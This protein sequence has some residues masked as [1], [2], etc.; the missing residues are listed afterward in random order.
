ML[1]TI[2]NPRRTI[3]KNVKLLFAFVFTL[4]LLL[5][6][7][8]SATVGTLLANRLESGVVQTE[9]GPVRGFRAGQTFAYLGVPFAAPPVGDLRWQ[10]PAALAC[11]EGE[12]QA[13]SFS[14][15]CPQA[16]D[17]GSV[18]G[19]EDCLYVNVWTPVGAS[20]TSSLPVMVFIHG[21]GNVQGSSSVQV[22]DVYLYDGQLLAERGQVVVMT[23]QYRLGALGFLA[24]PG[25]SAESERGISGN[26]GL[27]DQIAALKWVQRNIS[28]FGGDP[29]RVMIFGESAG[30]VD[31]CMLLASP[32]ATG[33]FSRA[34][35]ESGGC[36]ARTLA[37]RMDEGL[38][39]AS[40]AGC[41][42]A[43]DPV[44]CLRRLDAATLVKA[45]DTQPVNPT[46][47]VT[48]QFGPN[49]DGYVL[50]QPPMDA[51]RNGQH[52]HASFI[53]GANADE[54]AAFGIPP[55][56]Q[57]Q[58]REIVIQILGPTLGE[59][60]LAEYPVRE[61]GTPRQ[62]LIAMTTDAQFVCPCRTIARAAAASQ[63]EPV[64]RYF[65]TQRLSRLPGSALGAFHGL[66]LF[67]VFQRLELVQSYRATKDDLALQAAMLGYW[68]RFA[69]T[70]DP[71]RNGAVNWPRYDPVSDLYLELGTPITA[72]DG[73]RTD[74][75][76]FWDGILSGP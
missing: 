51:L 31:T 69:A 5:S 56:T 3:M 14:A 58:Y 1:E 33:L 44:A 64:F 59:L 38:E 57:R 32:L 16:A 60:A 35:M 43:S 48:Q 22:E 13:T 42:N 67:F 21:G 52:N 41:G 30:A 29:T 11:W 28:N 47:T 37:E 62:A 34:L 20:P 7:I 75:C 23:V 66:E 17:D 39:F 76:D 53:I 70:G 40:A 61:Y 45:V 74:K 46:G 50:S 9:C 2:G 18:I 54:T 36:G 8:E 73:V 15:P 26:Y 63:Q 72:G 24:H 71:S 4:V 19:N 12:L 25:L 27:L 49:V 10:P 68:T 55:L 65:F 6:S